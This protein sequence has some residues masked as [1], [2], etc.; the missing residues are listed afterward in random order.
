MSF[1]D[2]STIALYAHIPFCKSKCIYCDFFS[3]PIGAVNKNISCSPYHSYIQSLVS[4]ARFRQK[5]FSI[6]ALSSLYIGGGTP[7]LLNEDDL[8]LFF[9][10]LQQAFEFNTDI[11]ITLEANPDDINEQFL[12]GIEKFPINRISLGVQSMNEKTL[13]SCN[14]R[15]TVECNKRALNLCQQWAK[16]AG[17]SFSVDVIAGLP[18]ETIETFTSGMQTILNYQPTHISLYELTIEKNTSLFHLIEAGKIAYNDIK[19]YD[20]W[21]VG[22]K[23]LQKNMFLYYEVSNF[24]LPNYQSKHNLCYWNMKNYIGIGSGATGTVNDYRYKNTTDIQQWQIFFS[25]K[26]SFENIK[27]V[28]EIEK[29]EVNTQIFEYLM[30]GFRKLEGICAQTFFQ[31]FNQPIED[32]IEPLFSQW[33][34]QKRA[35]KTIYCDQTFYHLTED[36][37]L[38]LN[39]FL[40]LLFKNIK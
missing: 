31:R 21:R 11:E 26:P 22:K 35:C 23:I 4:E 18:H 34:Q 6:K 9:G 1:F 13:R 12:K 40:V 3:L 32:F 14:R 5:Q 29:L 16:S 38:F 39:Q 2:T 7:S 19:N 24:A 36:G 30:M 37:I 33:I 17:R 15:S 27:T 28:Q 10:Q 8:N 20:M 25:Q